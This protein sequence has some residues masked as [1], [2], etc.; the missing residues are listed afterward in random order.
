[1]GQMAKGLGSKTVIGIDRNPERLN[2]AL[3][4]ETRPMSRITGTFEGVH[5]EGSPARRIVLTLDF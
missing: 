4:V 1:M 3:S 5:E 2:R